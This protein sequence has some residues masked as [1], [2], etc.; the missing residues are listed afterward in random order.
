MAGNWKPAM[1]KGFV[2]LNTKP[3][4]GFATGSGKFEF[5]SAACAHDGKGG[6]FTGIEGA[7]AALPLVLVPC[8]SM[9]LASGPVADTPFVMKIVED[10]VLT[11]KDSWVEINGKTGGKCGL[12]EGVY[13]KLTVITSYSIHYTKL[14]D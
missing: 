1:E 13:A 14:Y 6:A 11:G 2:A 9:R 3:E 10:T 5:M 7:D 4:S 8:D 12:A